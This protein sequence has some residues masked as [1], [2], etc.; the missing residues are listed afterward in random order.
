VIVIG[1]SVIAMK[2][3]NKFPYIIASP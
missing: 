1:D 2:K 3:K